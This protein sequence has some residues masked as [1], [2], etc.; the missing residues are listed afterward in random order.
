MGKETTPL[1][2]PPWLTWVIGLFYAAGL[3][4][5]IY[6]FTGAYAPYG[7]LYPAAMALLTV[8]MFAGLSGIWNMEKWGVWVFTAGVVVKL[9][10]DLLAGAFQWPELALMVPAAAFLLLIK[11]M[12]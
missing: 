4:H 10:V 5:L 12:K 3:F 2:R 11:K 1:N 6:M 7:N 8:A 9:A